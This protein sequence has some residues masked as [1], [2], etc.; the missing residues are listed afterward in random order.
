MRFEEVAPCGAASL[1]IHSS[2]VFLGFLIFATTL[3]ASEVLLDLDFMLGDLALRRLWL[4]A[5]P[6]LE[7]ALLLI[8]VTTLILFFAT[9]TYT[10][11][12]AYAN[13]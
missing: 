9:G 4:P 13:K 7:L 1:L 10:E 2:A 12:I 5:F 11:K 6:Y 8:A 3:L